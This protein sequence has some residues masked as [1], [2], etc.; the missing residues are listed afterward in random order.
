MGRPSDALSSAF[1]PLAGDH[2]AISNRPTLGPSDILT[3]GTS[4]L[5]TAVVFHQLGAD[6]RELSSPGVISSTRSSML[7]SRKERDMLRIV[8]RV[9]QEVPW[10]GRALSDLFYTRRVCERDRSGV[11]ECR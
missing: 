1:G 11:W 9:E 2:Q 3:L 10:S 4:S 5:G 8:W 7:A 6:N